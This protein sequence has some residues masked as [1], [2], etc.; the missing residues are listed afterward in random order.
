MEGR[1]STWMVP[2]SVSI[3]TMDIFCGCTSWDSA[4]VGLKVKSRK[5]TSNLARLRDFDFPNQLP[6]M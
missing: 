2:F 4:V 6:C 5:C 1:D 3:I